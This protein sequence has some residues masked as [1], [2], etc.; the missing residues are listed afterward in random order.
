ML[1]ST[2]RSDCVRVRGAA[3]VKS[4][5]SAIDGRKIRIPEN[6]GFTI[7][8]KRL[9]VLIACELRKKE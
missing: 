4:L 1:R 8:E 6:W 5:K 2:L 7:S 3:T 9:F